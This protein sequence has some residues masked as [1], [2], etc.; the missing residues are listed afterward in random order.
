MPT[1]DY[2]CDSCDNEFEEVHRIADRNIPV[3]KICGVC[4]KGKIE[5]KIA[6]PGMADAARIGMKKPDAGFRDRL[7]EIKKAHR[8]SNIN[9]W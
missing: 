2:K 6:A 5:I 4:G 9:T 1:Y 7:K 8:G 3:G